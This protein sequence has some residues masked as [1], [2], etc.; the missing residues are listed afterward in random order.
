[1]PALAYPDPPLRDEHV[2]LRPWREEDLPAIAEAADDAAIARWNHLPQPYDLAAVRR[3]YESIPAGLAAG[4]TLRMLIADARDERRVL[5]AIAV[6]GLEAGSA[7]VGYWLAAHARGRGVASSPLRLLTLWAFERLGLRRLTAR[8]D[9]GNVA[10]RRLLERCGFVREGEEDGAPVYAAHRLRV[11]L[12]AAACGAFPPRDGAVEVLPPPP[13]RAM[14]VVALTAHHV[15]ATSAAEDWVRARLPAG[16][17]LAPMGPRFLA[18]LGAELGAR[19]DGID[20]VLAAPAL[21]GDAALTEADLDDH[22][23]VLRARAHREGVRVFADPS[24]AAVVALGR[25]LALRHEV[26]VEVDAAAS[27][28]GLATRVLADARRLLAPGETLF[29]QAAPGNAAALR[30]LLAAGFRPIGSEALLFAS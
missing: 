18:A 2:L 26:A 7:E 25:G 22:P 5:G 6:F 27:G 16:D 1:M 19:V 29:A 10:S 4:S 3:W 20:V 15:I 21:E 30:A 11:L 24:G 12:E 8:P 13:G 9:A 17:L 28:R 14:A 23:R